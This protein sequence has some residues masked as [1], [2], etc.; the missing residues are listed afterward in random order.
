[1]DAK[2]EGTQLVIKL[3][4][5]DPRPSGS[6]KTLVVAS[7]RGNQTTTA[8]ID[9]K[10]IVIGVNAYINAT[11]CPT[12]GVVTDYDT[13]PHIALAE[14]GLC[15]RWRDAQSRKA[16]WCAAAYWCTL[17]GLC[18]SLVALCAMGR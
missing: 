11:H 3:E 1:M 16:R 2:I 6:G 7:S 18:V 8:T 15:A 5:Q 13:V 17:A 9:G 14:C 12:C 4:L 10:P